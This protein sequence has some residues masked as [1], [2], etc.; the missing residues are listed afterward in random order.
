MNV[1]FVDRT[2][3]AD[4]KR[5]AEIVR[6]IALQGKDS[7]FHFEL[8]ADLIDGRTNGSAS[9]G[10]EREDAAGNRR[11]IHPYADAN[12]R[13]AGAGFFLYVRSRTCARERKKT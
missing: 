3:N 13:R 7:E 2:F 9:Y 10:E 4:R 8:A 1:K 11:A 5:A 6:D 12:S